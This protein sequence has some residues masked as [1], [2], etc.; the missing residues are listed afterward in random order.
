[1]CN[2]VNIEWITLFEGEIKDL[3]PDLRPAIVPRKA[4]DIIIS[5]NPLDLNHHIIF[6]IQLVPFVELLKP[7]INTYQVRINNLLK[8]RKSEFKKKKINW[9]IFYFGSKYWSFLVRRDFLKNNKW[10]QGFFFVF[11]NSAK[12]S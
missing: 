3:S 6:D 11:W 1:M 2:P 5:H 8:R 7:V 10:T 12:I 9:L 4:L